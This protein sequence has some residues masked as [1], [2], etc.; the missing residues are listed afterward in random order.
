M[1]AEHWQ[2]IEEIFNEALILPIEQRTLFIAQKSAGDI[3]LN[4]EIN[5]LVSEIERD[6][7]FLNDSVFTLCARLAKS[8]PEILRAAVFNGCLETVFTTAD[9]KHKPNQVLEKENL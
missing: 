4:D 1:K 5:A 6:D 8:E 9:S 7:K 2:K 3:E